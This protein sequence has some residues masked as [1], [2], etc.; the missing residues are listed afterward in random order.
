MSRHREYRG[1]ADLRLFGL[2]SVN[3]TAD[4]IAKE[5]E[6]LT[7]LLNRF[8]FHAELVLVQ[9]DIIP[10][11]KEV[12]HFAELIGTDVS[13]LSIT[14]ETRTM[15]NL[16]HQLKH[17]SSHAH[18]VMISLPVPKTSFDDRVYFA[19]LELLS[20]T[21]RPTFIARG[22]QQTVLSIHS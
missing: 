21:G 20:G 9:Y 5:K 13:S 19:Y 7:S 3:A 8:R 4:E 12:H 14:D 10:P 15:I 22:N 18:V 16:G 6:R 11:E 1:D 2:I 17:H